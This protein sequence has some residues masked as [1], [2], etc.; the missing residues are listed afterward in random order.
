MALSKQCFSQSLSHQRWA[1]VPF[2]ESP[3]SEVEMGSLGGAH[4]QLAVFV[5]LRTEAGFTLSFPNAVPCD[6][7]PLSLLFLAPPVPG[8]E[9]NVLHQFCCPPSGSSSPSSR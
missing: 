5:N 2:V 7:L 8:R 6:S 9:D 3:V 4:Q 1:A